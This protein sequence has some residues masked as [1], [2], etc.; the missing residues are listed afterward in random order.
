MKSEP[1]ITNVFEH[2]HGTIQMEVHSGLHARQILS[3]SP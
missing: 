1:H 3:S 2:M